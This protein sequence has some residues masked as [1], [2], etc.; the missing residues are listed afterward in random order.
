M[1]KDQGLTHAP[2]DPA[3][4]GRAVFRLKL[5]RLRCALTLTMALLSACDYTT[6]A[7]EATPTSHQ[8]PHSQLAYP[9]PART[10]APRSPRVI[11]SPMRVTFANRGDTVR[12]HIN[13]RFTLDLNPDNYYTEEWQI[14]LSD[15]Q[16]VTMVNQPALEQ[17]VFEAG[18]AGQTTLTASGEPTC[19]KNV[20]TPM[21]RDRPRLLTG[22]R[23]D[24]LDRQLP[25]SF[26]LHR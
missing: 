8:Q 19:R 16:V 12:L 2:A 15:P 3:A 4:R 7:V 17:W 9:S 23:G 13:E 1:T 20:S 6:S 26:W 25:R 5:M 10:A 14:K 21:R 22:D 18:K 11:A 24:L